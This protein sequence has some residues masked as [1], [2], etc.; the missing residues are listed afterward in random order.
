MSIRSSLSTSTT[1]RRVK[2][3]AAG[4]L[5]EADDLAKPV[6]VDGLR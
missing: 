2:A 5:G 6:A 1:E 4:A 3:V